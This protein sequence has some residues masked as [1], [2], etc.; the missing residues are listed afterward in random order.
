MAKRSQRK[1]PSNVWAEKALI[2]ASEMIGAP[3]TMSDDD[4]SGFARDQVLRALYG[5]WHSGAAVSGNNFARSG[6]DFAVS[7]DELIRLLPEP[8][9][10]NANGL[11]GAESLFRFAGLAETLMDHA[12][13]RGTR[14]AAKKT[15]VTRSKGKRKTQGM[16]FTPYELATHMVDECLSPVLSSCAGPV[17]ELLRLR[18]LDPAMGTGRF[19]LAAAE[20]I[21]GEAAPTRR[22]EIVDLR[23]K[24]VGSCLFGVDRSAFAIDAALCALGL[25]A[26]QDLVGG[27]L[28]NIRA[29]DSLVGPDAAHDFAYEGGFPESFFAADEE[30]GEKE[31]D[32]FDVIVGNPPY[33][34]SKNEPASFYAPYLGKAGQSDYYLLFIHKYVRRRYLRPGGAVSFVVPDPI[35][36]RH[37]AESVRLR[38]LEEVDLEGLIHARGLFAELGVANVVF[39]ARRPEGPRREKRE[40]LSLV[41][42]ARLESPAECRRYFQSGA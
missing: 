2:L 5:K 25:Y 6:D 23:R 33:V 42:V 14:P 37:N 1:K 35:L 31:F 3:S 36:C 9:P 13:S 34:A 21:T 22:E 41:K 17:D 30:G 10:R 28:N 26:E 11:H 4:L 7:G 15:H 19:L 8:P 32:G 38:L 29:G 27:G 18:V 40:S 39:L 24:V 16:F 20:R 12:L